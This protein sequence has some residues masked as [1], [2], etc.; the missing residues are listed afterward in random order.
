MTQKF[1]END[2]KKVKELISFIKKLDD[3]KDFQHEIDSSIIEIIDIISYGD[4]YI[5]E[6]ATENE[7][8]PEIVKLS[9]KKVHDLIKSEQQYLKKVL[10]IPNDDPEV[11]EIREEIKQEIIN[12]IIKRKSNKKKINYFKHV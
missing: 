6:L 10:C 3:E 12:K 7:F 1:N 8:F 9:F 4:V 5:S 2:I 11:Y